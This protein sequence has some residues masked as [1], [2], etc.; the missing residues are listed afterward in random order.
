LPLFPIS[1]DLSLIIDIILNFSVAISLRYFKGKYIYKKERWERERKKKER[2]REN[3]NKNR[4][5]TI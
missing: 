2:R 1:Y 4:N 3:K 5:L